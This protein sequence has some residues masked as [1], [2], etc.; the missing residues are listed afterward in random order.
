[1]IPVSIRTEPAPLCAVC[2]TPGEPRLQ[3]CLDHVTG[4]PGLWNFSE[5]PDCQSLWLNPCPVEADI[6]LLYPESYKLTRTPTPLLSDVPPGFNGSAKLA[7][8][9]LFYGYRALG[10]K[11]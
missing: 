1:M 2:S 4:I 8:L 6:P 3:N 7:V 5:C 10:K 9:E 11:G